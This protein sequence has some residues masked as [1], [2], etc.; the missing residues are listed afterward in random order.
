MS[1]VT[2]KAPCKLGKGELRRVP[3]NL[4]SGIVGYHVCCPR[5]GFVTIAIQGS[6]GLA[7]TEGDDAKTVTFSVTV[8]CAYCAVLI[9]L[10]GGDFNLEEDEHVRSIR[11]R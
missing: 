7:I 9:G 10:S 1:R 2:D 6:R 5:C 3:Q 11:Y 4:R 8:R